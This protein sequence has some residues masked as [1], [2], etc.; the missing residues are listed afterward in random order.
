[1]AGGVG[2]GTLQCFSLGGMSHTVAPTRWLWIKS[3][4]YVCVHMYV[5]VCIRVWWNDKVLEWRAQPLLHTVLHNYRPLPRSP[6]LEATGSSY[7]P[8]DIYHRVIDQ[9]LV[10][11]WDLDSQR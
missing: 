3:Y 7:W 11:H 4:K 8:K 10:T 6:A 2:E 9:W 1:L 5:Y